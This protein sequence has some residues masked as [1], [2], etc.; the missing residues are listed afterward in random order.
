MVIYGVAI[1][2]FCYIIGQLVGELL[3]RL[4]HIDG[5]VGGV[6]FAMLLLILVHQYMDKKKWFSPEMDKGIMFW[7]Q[8]FI[9]AIV[10]MS[11]SQ[12]VVL[13]V[14]GGLVALLAG[15]LAVG[16]CFSLIP[17]FSKVF[18]NQLAD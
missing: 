14:N 15:V 17:L 7:N 10:A 9:P 8:M 18:K 12:N 13:A 6:G 4:L 16:V 2:S 1:L 3:G 11:A 5:N